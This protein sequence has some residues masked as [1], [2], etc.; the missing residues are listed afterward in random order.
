MIDIFAWIVLIVVVASTVA[1]VLFLAAL[2]G[3]IA[4]K[5]NHP[6]AQ[7]VTVAGWVTFFLGFALWP[8][9]AAASAIGA[10]APIQMVH[11]QQPRQKPDMGFGQA[12]EALKNG[13]RVARAGWNGMSMYTYLLTVP[14]YEP[15]ICMHTAQGKEQPGWLASQ[16]DILS[17]DWEIAA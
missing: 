3:M 11:A 17:A 2:P 16:P 7:A 10:N 12:I 6:W 9:V 8:L 4:N 14:G 15:G 1:V 13:Q 5:R